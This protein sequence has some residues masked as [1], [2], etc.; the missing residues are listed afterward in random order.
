MNDS[1]GALDWDGV[2]EQRT[3]GTQAFKSLV[4]TKHGGGR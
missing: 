4:I 3:T 2:A 1:I